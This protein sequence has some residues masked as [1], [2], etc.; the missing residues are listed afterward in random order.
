M[1]NDID[2]MSTGELRRRIHENEIKIAR[3]DERLKVM[4]EAAVANPEWAEIARLAAWMEA[5]PLRKQVPKPTVWPDG[6]D[7]DAFTKGYV[8]KAF[9]RMGSKPAEDAAISETAKQ[10]LKRLG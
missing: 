2:N 1:N 4:M 5:E 10:Y 7:C 8:A 3:N 6:Y 9:A